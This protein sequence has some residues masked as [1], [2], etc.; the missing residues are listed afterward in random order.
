VVLNLDPFNTQAGF[1][2]LPLDEFHI[3][4]DQRYQV[5]D[6]LSD[7]RYV[8]TGRRNYVELNPASIPAHIFLI[9]RRLR[10]EADFEYFL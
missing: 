1:V 4:E 5:H 6:Q 10:G 8:W 3:E 9:R 2:T 7:A